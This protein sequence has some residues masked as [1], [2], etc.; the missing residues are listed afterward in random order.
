MTKTK[1]GLLSATAIITIVASSLAILC[2][3]VMMFVGSMINEQLIK[4]SY[5]VDS[6]YTLYEDADGNYYFSHIEDN[7][8]EV[9]ITDDEI[10]LMATVTSN[11]ANFA[12]FT[13]LGLGVAK[14]VL[15]IRILLL[16]NREKYSLGCVIALLV[17]SIVNFNVLE[18]VFLVVTMCVK[19]QPK[20]EIEDNSI[21]TE[22][23]N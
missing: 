20:V 23:E 21:Q 8:A 16:K 5:S 3:F 14:L 2:G 4:D 6:E 18:A 15:A 9:R 7:G 22:K 10:S 13:I 1:K 11:I 12:G 19:D 17:L